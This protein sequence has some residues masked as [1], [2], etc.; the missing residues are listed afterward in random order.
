ML[1]SHIKTWWQYV[2]DGE[3][4]EILSESFFDDFDYAALRIDGAL[5]FDRMDGRTPVAVLCAVGFVDFGL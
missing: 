4:E 3:E 2:N 5:V 1:Y